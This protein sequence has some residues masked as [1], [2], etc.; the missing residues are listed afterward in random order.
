MQKVKLKFAHSGAP[1]KSTFDAALLVAKKHPHTRVREQSENKLVL[2]RAREV[3]KVISS[4]MGIPPFIEYDE[5]WELDLLGEVPRFLI[6]SEADV[7]L[8][9]LK[10]GTRFQQEAPKS[11]GFSTKKKTHVSVV[12]MVEISGL[13]KK[14]GLVPLI[15][16]FIKGE[17][18]YLRNMERRVLKK[19]KP[20]LRSRVDEEEEE[21]DLTQ[22]QADEEY[23]TRLADMRTQASSIAA[24]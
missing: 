6:S 16:T 19:M 14:Q 13:G 9:R 2:R 22:E 4:V 1:V 17:F 20:M 11:F 7:G 18:D 23:Q 12:T 15:K 10:V 24:P 3:D 5:H 8:Y 21:E